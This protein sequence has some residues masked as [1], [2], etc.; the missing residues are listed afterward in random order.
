MSG[1]ER[2]DK[3]IQHLSERDGPVSGSQLA[4]MLHVSRQVIV[5][6]VALL[7]AAGHGILATS[8]GYLLQRRKMEQREFA[9]VLSSNTFL[10]QLYAIVDLG[11]HVMEIRGFFPAYGELSIPLNVK[12][13]KDAKK[14]LEGIPFGCSSPLKD[15]FGEPQA[16]SHVEYHL[17]VEADAYEDLDLIEEDLR[18]QGYL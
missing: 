11:G 5:Q 14:I 17:R 8:N 3:I 2:R 4:S 13:R 10:E 12:S 16:I 9:M 7:K 1:E 6:D 18:N 15:L